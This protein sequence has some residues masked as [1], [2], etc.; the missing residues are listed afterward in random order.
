MKTLTK[1]T[2]IALLMGGPGSEREVSITSGKAV[3]EAL[4]QEG[5]TRVTPV[6]VDSESPEIPA[7]TEL[8]YNI[9]HGT[10]GEDGGLQSYLEKL[11]L[12]YTGAG[13]ETSRKCFDKVL[14]KEAFVAAGVPTPASE[15]ITAEQMPTIPVPCV[16]KP[17]CEGSSVG[18]QIVKTAE[19]LAPA[20]AEAGKYGKDLLVE[21]FIEGKELTVA[22]FNGKALPV[23]H[24]CPRSGFYDM[25]N[26]YPSLY[27]GAGSDYICPADISPEETKAVQEAALAA[28]NALSVEVYG[29]VDVL[30]TADGKPYV[31]E[32]NTIPGMTSASLF[33]KAAKAVGISF[34]ELCTQIAEISLNQPRG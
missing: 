15:V 6:V 2:A 9:I 29:R 30:L 17:P 10:Y 28:Y 26:K 12:P 34:G 14:T 22:I 31:L 7:G 24:I 32:I 5:F 19:E 4:Q 25:N 13:S 1:D 21:E 27:G 18:V 33:P 8:C 16:I 11:G 3:L 23:I 20:V